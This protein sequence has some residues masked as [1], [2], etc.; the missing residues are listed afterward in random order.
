MS[1]G[2]FTCI[3][4]PYNEAQ[5][6]DEILCVV[7][8]HPLLNEVIVVNGS[9]DNTADIVRSSPS[10]R[11]IFS[12]ENRGKSRAFAEAVRTA[13]NDYIMCLDGDL[14]HLTAAAPTK[15]SLNGRLATQMFRARFRSAGFCGI[16]RM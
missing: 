6:I 2:I 13:K 10:V 9:T 15:G 4:C 14:K 7:A 16:F 1:A 8:T 12:A 5:S 11:L 3:I